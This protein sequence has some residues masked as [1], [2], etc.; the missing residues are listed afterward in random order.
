GRRGEGLGRLLLEERIR[1]ARQDPAVERIVIHTSHRT[2]GFFEH[3]GFRAVGVEEDGIAPGLHAV[4][5]VLPLN[6]RCA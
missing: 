4:D 6:P 3:M 5:M 1:R 2:R